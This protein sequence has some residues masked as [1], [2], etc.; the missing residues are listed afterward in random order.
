MDTRGEFYSSKGGFEVGLGLAESMRTA[1][2]N[3][4][5]SRNSVLGWQVEFERKWS[6]WFM[7][8]MNSKIAERSGCVASPENRSQKPDKR[9]PSMTFSHLRVIIVALLFTS[10]A[11]SEAPDRIDLSIDTYS[12]PS[13]ALEIAKT[14]AEEYR[15]K[16]QGQIGPDTRYLAVQSDTIF[17]DEIPDIYHQLVDSPGVNSS[18]LES[19]SNNNELEIYCVNIFDIRTGRLDPVGYAVVD[20]PHVGSPARFGSYT[21]RFIGTGG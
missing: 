12:P 16:H 4:R 15:A 17:S 18:N 11:E 21:A 2:A 19:Y 8:G 14:H 13:N 9:K 6:G 20:L 1:R 7:A 10:C 3:D 5:T